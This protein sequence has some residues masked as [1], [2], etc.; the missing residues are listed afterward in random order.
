MPSGV[1]LRVMGAVQDGTTN[2]FST[3]VPHFDAQERRH[4]LHQVMA[5]CSKTGTEV[6]MV[7]D[8][9]GMPRAH[10]RDATLEHSHSTVRFHCFPAHWGPHRNPLEGFG[11]VRQDAIGAGRCFATLPLFSQRTRQVLMAH[12]ERPIDA[13]HG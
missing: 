12:Q 5:T 7:V 3:L 4:D 11:R 1:W 2:V 10:K 6:V 8:R 13:C 9:R